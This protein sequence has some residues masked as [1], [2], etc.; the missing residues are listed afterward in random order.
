MRSRVGAL[1]KTALGGFVLVSRSLFGFSGTNEL[2]FIEPIST[3][4]PNLRQ[5]ARNSDRAKKPAIK[6]YRHSTHIFPADLVVF[7]AT[8]IR[9]FISAI[10]V[11]AN[12][13][14]NPHP[15]PWGQAVRAQLSKSFTSCALAIRPISH[16]LASRLYGSSA[17]LSP[18]KVV[19]GTFAESFEATRSR[20]EKIVDA[21]PTQWA[22]D[23]ADDHVVALR[24]RGYMYWSGQI[25]IA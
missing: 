3:A 18:A 7:V 22:D 19:A 5:I 1:G 25:V 6:A 11:P 13:P 20:I 15:V 23:A 16:W 4:K 8:H 2:C 24:R 21:A 14:Q 9:I 12:F 10:R 17:V